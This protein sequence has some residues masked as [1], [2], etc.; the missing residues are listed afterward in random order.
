VQGYNDINNIRKQR[1]EN[2][3][4]VPHVFLARTPL[5]LGH[6]QLVIPSRTEDNSFRHAAKIIEKVIIVF[7]KAFSSS[8]VHEKKEFMELA[9]ITRTKGKYIKLLI[10]RS[11]ASEDINKEY[12]VHL[13]P[14]F[15]AH[16]K[17]CSERFSKLH[18]LLPGSQGGLLGWLGERENEV[19]KW[20]VASYLWKYKLDE[21]ANH[22]WNM[23]QLAE[24]LFKVSK[25]I[26]K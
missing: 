12:K 13:V 14:Y 17:E 22:D 8:K 6:S 10:L 3:S 2:L 20:E 24:E 19:D 7:K 23:A 5:T 1:W 25:S 4:S 21:I 15:S 16:E 18:N 26:G 11:S 9:D